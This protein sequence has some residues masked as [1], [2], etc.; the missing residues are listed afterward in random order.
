MIPNKIGTMAQ[1]VE[2]SGDVT[3]TISEVAQGLEL[4]SGKA[5]AKRNI[6][7]A[8]HAILLKDIKGIR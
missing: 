1:K 7:L 3:I 4:L 8:L 2:A 5:V 6:S